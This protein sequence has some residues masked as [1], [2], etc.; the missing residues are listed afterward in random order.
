[1]YL[2]LSNKYRPITLDDVIGQ[3]VLV[4]TIQNSIKLGR[5]SSV[6]LFSGP[7]GVG[8]TTTAR[9]I[10]RCVN[11]NEGITTHPCFKCSSCIS[12]DNLSHPDVVEIDAASNTGV[13]DIRLVI[14][15]AKFLP[16]MSRFKV[17]IIDE[18]HMLSTS[19]FNALLKTLEE[20]LPHV[21]FIMATT[22]LNKVPA[23]IISRCQRFNLAKVA[24]SDMIK[25]LSNIMNKEGVKYNSEAIKIIV[26]AANGSV[27]DSLSILE[28]ILLY[29]KSGKLELEITKKF[30]Y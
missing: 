9:I 6:F 11:C 27:R 12:M 1:V 21:K 2:S 20:P 13:D 18:V 10:A 19:A 28:Q 14:E 16:I 15:N 23:T 22:E 17:Y 5:I 7:Y 29:S 4:S 26:E 25:N 3:E 24:T 8:K 30:L